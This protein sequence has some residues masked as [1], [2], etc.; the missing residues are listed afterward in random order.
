MALGLPSLVDLVFV[1][2]R[3]LPAAPAAN[4]LARAEQRGGALGA[5]RRRLRSG[6][7]AASGRC[8]R[9]PVAVPV[10]AT[11]AGEAGSLLARLSVA[12]CAPARRRHEPDRDRALAVGGEHPRAAAVGHDAHGAGV[13]AAER[14]RAGGRGRGAVAGERD[15]RHRAGGAD[16][17]AAEVR[18]RRAVHEHR[19]AGVDRERAARGVV[20]DVAD[21]LDLDAA[22]ARAH[23]RDRDDLGPVVGGGGGEHLRERAAAVERQADLDLGGVDAVGVGACDV[24]GDGQRRAAAGGSGGGLGREPERPGPGR[25]GQRD[26]G[27]VEAAE[28]RDGCR[29]R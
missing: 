6:S 14:E 24:P 16:G 8:R 19:R 28:A 25:D 10:S 13:R 15:R 3:R 11:V 26:V 7:A 20:E 17:R 21:G 27:A 18:G 4:G 5:G 22:V 2:R 1:N 12:D 29:V 23:A 9:R